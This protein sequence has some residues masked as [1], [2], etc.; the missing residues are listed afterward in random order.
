MVV[1]TLSVTSGAWIGAIIAFLLGRYI[2]REASE[3]FAQK[4]RILKALDR[5]LMNEGLKVIMLLRLSPIVPCTFLNYALGATSVPFKDYVLGSLFII[6][7]N[8]IY[9]L[10]GTT[11]G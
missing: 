1:G 9:V 2:F 11:S 5:A 3:Q 10:I 7:G 4:Y 6:P 8:V